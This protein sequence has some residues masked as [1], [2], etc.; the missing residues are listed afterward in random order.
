MKIE[1]QLSN[2]EIES[3]YQ[4]FTDPPVTE[5][6]RYKVTSAGLLVKQ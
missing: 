1:S 5:I 4:L 2:Q 6:T 3:K